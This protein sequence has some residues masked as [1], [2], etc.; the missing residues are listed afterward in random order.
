MK[1]STDSGMKNTIEKIK[2]LQA[3]CRLAWD[4]WNRENKDTLL[5]KIDYEFYT[6]NKEGSQKFEEYLVEQGFTVNIN[7]KRIM[8]IFKGYEI[9]AS[10]EAEWSFVEFKQS[11]HD[12]GIVARQFDCLIEGY[13]AFTPEK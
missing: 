13:G 4:E 6:A 7:S 8:I 9:K 1:E 5:I 11:L 2:N 12:I 10:Y 3:D